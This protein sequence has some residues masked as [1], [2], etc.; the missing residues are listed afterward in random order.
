[1]HQT[2]SDTS[3]VRIPLSIIRVE[4]LRLI[5]N[6]GN[7]CF[8]TTRNCLQYALTAAGHARDLSGPGDDAASSRLARASSI[9][10]KSWVSAGFDFE[11]LVIQH[12][13]RKL[14]IKFHGAQIGSMFNL[15]DKIWA[16]MER[17]DELP[18]QHC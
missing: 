7:S 1:M 14:I 6:I 3:P 12:T 16:E 9:R 10:T 8:Q 2:S 11:A 18:E 5:T 17:N 13:G 4:S 15:R